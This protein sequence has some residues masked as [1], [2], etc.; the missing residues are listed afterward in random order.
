MSHQKTGEIPISACF[1][2]PVRYCSGICR[3][4]PIGEIWFRYPPR[5]GVT[6]HMLCNP[7]RINPVFTCLYLCTDLLDLF[8]ADAFLN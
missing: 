3:V 7:H 6:E 8:A 1:R 2:M 4:Q 5:S